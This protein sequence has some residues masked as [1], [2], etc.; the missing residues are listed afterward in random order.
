MLDPFSGSGST[1]LAAIEL[2]CTYIGF[3]IDEMQVAESRKRMSIAQ[4]QCNFTTAGLVDAVKPKS[5]I[6]KN[7]RLDL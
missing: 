5:E 6:V 1:G 2:G 7:G 4:E 3:E